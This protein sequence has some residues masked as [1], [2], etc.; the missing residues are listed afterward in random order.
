MEPID[1][2]NRQ[3]RPG[4]PKRPTH[5]NKERSRASPHKPCVVLRIS[6]HHD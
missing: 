3:G 1:P 2:L 6:V 5:G 4:G